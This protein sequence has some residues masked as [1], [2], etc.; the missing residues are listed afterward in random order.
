MVGTP[1]TY[2]SD[3]AREPAPPALLSSAAA[4]R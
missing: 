2:D 4:A 3:S 1:L